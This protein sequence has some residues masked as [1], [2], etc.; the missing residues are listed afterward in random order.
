MLQY[1]R[2]PPPVPNALLSVGREKTIEFYGARLL[3][4]KKMR[5]KR[6]QQFSRLFFQ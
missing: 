5:L 2:L 1:C 4:E 3:G 6:K